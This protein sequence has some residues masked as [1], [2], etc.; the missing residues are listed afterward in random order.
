MKPM[1]FTTPEPI[2][3]N[4]YSC[5]SPPFTLPPL[6]LPTVPTEREEYRDGTKFT[7]LAGMEIH[8]TMSVRKQG[9]VAHEE[10]FDRIALDGLSFDRL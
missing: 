10:S 4:G 6:Y 8:A 9:G 3:G 7:L 2:G 5:R 1:F